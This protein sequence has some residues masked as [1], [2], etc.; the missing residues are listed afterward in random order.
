MLKI[1]VLFTTLVMASLVFAQETKFG[2]RAGLNLA[3]IEVESKS[4]P[5]YDNTIGFH[6]GAIVDI[7]ISESFYIQP[8]ILFSLKGAEYSENY[9][10]EIYDTIFRPCYLE[11][12]LLVSAK[13]A[14][15]E[16]LDIRIN[17][18]PYMGL[19]LYGTSFGTTVEEKYEN[20]D[21]PQDNYSDLIDWPFKHLDFGLVFGTGIEFQNFY[22]GVNY[23]LGLYNV[24]EF[25]YSVME[26]YNRC[27]GITLGYNF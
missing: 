11:I 1:I 2:F 15:N 20:F 5:D 4:V 24:A 27:L 23:D 22:I 18:G 3:S 17:V 16:S 26:H 21:Y 13:I 19:L 6:I 7:G 10:H 25:S 8:G 12:P 14:I 9:G